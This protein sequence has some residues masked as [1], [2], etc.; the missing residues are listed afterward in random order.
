MICVLHQVKMQYHGVEAHNRWKLLLLGV[1]L[2][3][4]DPMPITPGKYS[5]VNTATKYYLTSSSNTTPDWNH[6]VW[7]TGHTTKSNHQTVPDQ[8]VSA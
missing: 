1:L 6:K 7:V 4:P 8:Q 2:P 3:A 5:I